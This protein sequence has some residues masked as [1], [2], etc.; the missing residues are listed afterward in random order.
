LRHRLSIFYPSY[1]P[2]KHAPLFPL[3]K[4]FDA[5]RPM[6]ENISLAIAGLAHQSSPSKDNGLVPPPYLVHRRYRYQVLLHPTSRV[7]A[8]NWKPEGF[9]QVAYHLAL[10]GM[11]PLFC[12]GP[13]ERSAWS[14][15]E[16]EG[17]GLPEIPSLSCLAALMYESGFVIGNDSL[18][19]HLASNLAIPHLVIANDEK[20]MRLWRPDWL[21]GQLVLPPS[22]LPNWKM[23]RLREKRW[24]N[25]ISTRQV[26]RTFNTLQ[27]PI[28]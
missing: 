9:L 17:F 19:C 7:P 4:V 16:K 18:A 13:W 26:L 2:N 20:R 25:F 23:L 28:P 27:V 24:Q 10:R 11:Q 6:A 21:K 5:K 14:F 12:V 3:D 15:V 8:K 22:F 1:R